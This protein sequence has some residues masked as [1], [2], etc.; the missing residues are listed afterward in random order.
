MPHAVISG[1]PPVSDVFRAYEALLYRNGDIVLKTGTAYLS[2]DGRSMVI[3][4]TAVEGGSP[5][6]FL[7]LAGQ[8]EGGLVVRL[9][10]SIEVEKT[11]GV[12]RLLAMVAMQV[13][14]KFPGTSLGKTNLQDFLEARE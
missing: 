12:K 3:E 6:N 11:D 5:R 13:M 7:V 10:P 9:H 8:R 1:A 2:S 4:A 14:G